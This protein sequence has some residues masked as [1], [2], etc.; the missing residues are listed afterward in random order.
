[1]VII[2]KSFVAIIQQT[3][4][5]AVKEYRKH[6]NKKKTSEEKCDVCF[7]VVSEKHKRSAYQNKQNGGQQTRFNIITLH[8]IFAFIVYG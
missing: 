4:I 2:N 1:M 7:I 8:D 3:T 6:D 5:K